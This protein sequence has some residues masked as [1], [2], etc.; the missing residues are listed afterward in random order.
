MRGRPSTA[1]SGAAT[2]LYAAAALARAVTAAAGKDKAVVEHV[3]ADEAKYRGVAQ[4][5][6][7]RQW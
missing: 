6:A 5:L 1:S 2:T 3:A 4:V 7:I